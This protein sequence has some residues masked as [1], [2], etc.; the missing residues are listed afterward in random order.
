[1]LGLPPREPWPTGG[2]EW[3]PAGRPLALVP[4]ALPSV[5]SLQL[6]PWA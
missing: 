6:P 5:A 1:M 3:V 4:G 2:A